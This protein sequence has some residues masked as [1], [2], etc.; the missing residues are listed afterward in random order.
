MYLKMATLTEISIIRKIQKLIEEYQLDK[1]RKL[2]DVNSQYVKSKYN[3][4]I[5]FAPNIRPDWT[6]ENYW[7][8]Y[9]LQIQNNKRSSLFIEKL[10]IFQKN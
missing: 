7:D 3:E 10:P 8:W 5:S 1:R 2:N 9:N 4:L 6:P